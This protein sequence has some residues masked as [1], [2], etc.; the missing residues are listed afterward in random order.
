[1][2]DILDYIKNYSDLVEFSSEDNAYLAKC[3]EL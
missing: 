3:L 2:I 1:M